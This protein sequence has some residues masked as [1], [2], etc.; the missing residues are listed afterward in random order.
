M[1]LPFFLLSSNRRRHREDECRLLL[2]RVASHCAPPAVSALSLLQQLRSASAPHLH[3]P[4]RNARFVSTCIPAL[5]RHLRGGMEVGRIFEAYGASGSGKTQLALSAAVQNALDRTGATV[6][7]DTSSRSSGGTEED[8]GAAAPDGEPAVPAAV[9]TPRSLSALVLE[10]LRDIASHRLASTTSASSSITTA[11]ILSNVVSYSVGDAT[12]LLRCIDSLEEEIVLRNHEDG[13]PADE[14]MDC[15]ETTLPINLIV[16]DSLAQAL[17]SETLDREG[18]AA[19]APGATSLSNRAAYSLAVAQRLKRIA[20]E[21]NVAVLVMN[22]V[23][24]VQSSAG[25]EGGG[26]PATDG[27]TPPPAALGTAWHHCVSMRVALQHRPCTIPMPTTGASSSQPPPSLALPQLFDRTAVLT[28][29]SVVPCPAGPFGFG[30]RSR[31]VVGEV[32]SRSV[33]AQSNY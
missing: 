32:E 16:L 8:G 23:D 2:R 21:H 10:R 29:S 9:R 19:Q 33:P 1:P 14:P 30:I 7:I 27:I 28:K 6:Y 17:R 11:T 22:H 25:G 3:G 15:D 5:D 26:G 18:E 13:D 31:G 12:E 20:M 4:R 24:M